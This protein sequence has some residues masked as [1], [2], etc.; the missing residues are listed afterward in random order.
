MDMRLFWIRDR[1]EQGQFRV[2]WKPGA[3]NHGDYF[4]KHHTAAHHR[5]MRPQYLTKIFDG[6]PNVQQSTDCAT[7]TL[8]RMA[9]TCEGVLKPSPSVP[10]STTQT[11]TAS[12]R[13]RSTCGRRTDS[14]TRYNSLIVRYQTN[15]TSTDSHTFKSTTNNKQTANSITLII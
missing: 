6:T 9:C 2:Q 1:C 11:V 3:T 13:S 8:S 12:P 5:K 15:R 7:R 14:L 10:G 4:S